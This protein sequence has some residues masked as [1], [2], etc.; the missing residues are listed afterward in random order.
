MKPQPVFQNQ[1]AG[2]V[3]SLADVILARTGRRSALAG[4]AVAVLAGSL[5]V[6]LSAK[7]QAPTWPVPITLQPWAVLLVGAALGARR[8]AIALLLYLLE[9]LAGLPVFAGPVAGPAYFAGPTAGYLLA[10][11][12]AAFLVGR[13]AQRGWDRRPWTALPA[14]LMGHALILAVG[15]AWL[16]GV[17]GLRRGFLDGVA[18]FWIGDV[19]KILL[20]AISFPVAW[21]LLRAVGLDHPADRR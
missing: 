14:L 3:G 8:G 1:G 10:F 7:V 18:R 5:L 11:P 9:G 2:M 21:R 12:L 6:A 13:L 15:F 16:A 20:A 17:V 19:L 4:S